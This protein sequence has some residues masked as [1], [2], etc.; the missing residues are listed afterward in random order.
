VREGEAHRRRSDVQQNVQF[1]WISDF[2][3]RC[4]AATI[5]YDPVGSGAGIKRFIDGEADFAGSDVPLTAEEQRAADRRCVGQ[6]DD[7]ASRKAKA[8]HIPIVV[9]ASSSSTTFPES[10]SCTSHRRR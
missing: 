1:R 3:T 6:P 10:R 8:V 4:Y 2:T 9:C 5:T 7:Q